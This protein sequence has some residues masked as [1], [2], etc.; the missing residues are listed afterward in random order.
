MVIGRNPVSQR[1]SVRVARVGL[2]P[3]RDKRGKNN[4]QS[5]N[6][7]CKHRKQ[8]RQSN[9]SRRKQIFI[10]FENLAVT[11]S[12]SEG[13]TAR[14]TAEQPDGVVLCNGLR[15]RMERKLLSAC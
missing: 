15:R 8:I 11:D 6:R 7:G 2:R 13:A 3:V 10:F 4:R 1:S 14:S 12:E 5:L 9:N